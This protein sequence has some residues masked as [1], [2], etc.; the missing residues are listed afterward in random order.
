MRV[1]SVIPVVFVGAVT[2][3]GAAKRTVAV[4]HVVM[5]CVVEVRVVLAGVVASRSAVC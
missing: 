2:A 1:V 3:V 4:A 5:G